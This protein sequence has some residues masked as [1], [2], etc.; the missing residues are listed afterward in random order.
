MWF[1]AVTCLSLGAPSQFPSGSMLPAWQYIDCWKKEL[2][3]GYWQKTAKTVSLGL[4]EH[5][6][7]YSLHQLFDKSMDKVLKSK[8]SAGI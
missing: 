3:E 6:I 4:P 5:A 2:T 8:Y 7:H 1:M